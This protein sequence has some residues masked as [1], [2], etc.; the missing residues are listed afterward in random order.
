MSALYQT[1]LESIK[2]WADF[3]KKHFPTGA[4]LLTVTLKGHLIVEE[5]LTSIILSHCTS[6]EYLIDAK[7]GFYKKVFLARALFYIPIDLG[8]WDLALKLNTIRNDFAHSLEPKNLQLHL[9]E[10][11]LLSQKMIDSPEVQEQL[12]TTNEGLMFFMVGHLTGMFANF[13][14]ATKMVKK[15]KK[16]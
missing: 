16:S 9:D 5:Q 2:H 10:A 6:P 15:H 12:P 13:D 1:Y 3:Q 4:D 14:A 7:L 8:I 11:R